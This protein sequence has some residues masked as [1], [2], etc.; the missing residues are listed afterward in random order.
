MVALLFCIPGSKQWN[1]VGISC[2]WHWMHYNERQFPSSSLGLS[3]LL[4]TQLWSNHQL[5]ECHLK[6]LFTLTSDFPV[7]YDLEWLNQP[8]DLKLNFTKVHYKT[9]WDAKPPYNHTTVILEPISWGHLGLSAPFP[10]QRCQ[11]HVE[12]SGM[13]FLCC[14]SRSFEIPAP[15]QAIL[16]PAT[17]MLTRCPD[18]V[19]LL[20]HVSQRWSSVHP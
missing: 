16:G 10:V 12:S 8:S 14:P 17:I 4:K 2:I 5:H 11:M 9:W 13:R 1:R 20:G 3:V 19:I 15:P 6:S 7:L 18:T